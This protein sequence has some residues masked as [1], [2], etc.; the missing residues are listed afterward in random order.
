MHVDW[1]CS[2]KSYSTCD[3]C[4]STVDSEDLY[5]N[6]DHAPLCEDYVMPLE[7]E[8][9]CG[10]CFNKLIDSGL[11]RWKTEVELANRK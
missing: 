3:R 4:Q 2:M 5:W 6:E 8:S 7:Y 11:A 10:E 1:S 9:V